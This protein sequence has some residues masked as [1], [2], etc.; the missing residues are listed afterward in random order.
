M[1]LTSYSLSSFLVWHLLKVSIRSDTF[2]ISMNLAGG[3]QVLNI[4]SLTGIPVP[5]SP[6]MTTFSLESSLFGGRIFLAYPALYPFAI[7]NI[8][9]LEFASL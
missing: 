2:D 8:A 9:A 5:A 6:S 1:I 4:D 3:T 7:P